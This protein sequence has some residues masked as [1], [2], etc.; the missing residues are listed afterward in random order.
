MTLRVMGTPPCEAP[1]PPVRVAVIDED[2]TFAAILASAFARSDGVVR[3]FPSL[4]AAL[5]RATPWRLDAILLVRPERE[6]AIFACSELR[7]SGFRGAVLIVSDIADPRV[8]VQALDS[9]AD[10]Y[11]TMPVDVDVLV[12]R[13]LAVLRRWRDGQWSEGRALEFGA[14]R[15]DARAEG[16]WVGPEYK[17]LAPLRYRLLEL[18]VALRGADLPVDQIS[19]L[20]HGEHRSLQAVENL[21]W[22]LRRDIGCD[23]DIILRR[24]CSIALA[25]HPHARRKASGVRPSAAR[26]EP[27]ARKPRKPRKPRAR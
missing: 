6:S 22:Q 7:S 18:L 8:K 25:P 2:L 20:V 14:I 11:V 16:A 10:A 21:I 9:G 3:C 15:L 1:A 26:S 5:P 23:G 13:T 17:Q 27:A 19:V 12:A 24:S 4:A